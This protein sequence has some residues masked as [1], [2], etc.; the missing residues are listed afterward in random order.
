MTIA[1][2]R[3]L[4]STLVIPFAL[5]AASASAVEI[6]DWGYEVNNTFTDW[7]ESAGAGDVTA[8]DENRK[9]TWGGDFTSEFPNESSISITNVAAENGLITN[10]GFVNGGVFTHTNKLISVNDAALLSFRL[11]SALTL[12]PAAPAG[13]SLVPTSSTFASFFKETPNNGNCIAGSLS[14]CDD[15]FTVGNVDELGGMETDDGFEFASPS[16]TIDDYTYT[17]FLELA[18]LVVL[19]DDAC[20]VAGASAGCIGLLTQEN[21]VNNFATRFRIASSPVSV[22]EPGT[23]ALLGLGLAGLGVSSR[24]KAAKA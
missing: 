16:F 3:T 12:T 2:K 8:S 10:G 18:G 1:L 11:N 9:L 14:N 6:T 15:I 21:A 13:A 20:G 22:P 17:V 24:K 7:T 4:L 19:G 23:L 5:G